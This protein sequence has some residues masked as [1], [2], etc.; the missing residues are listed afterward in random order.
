M[1]REILNVSP[2]SDLGRRSAHST[3]AICPTDSLVSEALASVL[4]DLLDLPQVDGF[5]KDRSGRSAE[6][7]ISLSFVDIVQR[8][9]TQINGLCCMCV[10]WCG[11]QCGRYRSDLRLADVWCEL[12]CAVYCEL[13]VADAV[14]VRWCGENVRVVWL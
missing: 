3:A 4:L 12:R 1:Y 13:R 11:E 10:R 9:C 5:Q 6:A 14:E 2:S 7:A 8:S